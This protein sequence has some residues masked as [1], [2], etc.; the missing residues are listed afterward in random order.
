V[1]ITEIEEAF[2]AAAAHVEVF[3]RSESLRA[4]LL[5]EVRRDDAQALS[6]AKNPLDRTCYKL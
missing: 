4:L 1:A 5:G 3:G 6:R 2:T